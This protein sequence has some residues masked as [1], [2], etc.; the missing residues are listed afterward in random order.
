MTIL[1]SHPRMVGLGL[2]QQL[3]PLQSRKEKGT[4]GTGV[5]VREGERFWGQWAI[6]EML[7]REAGALGVGM[8]S[9]HLSQK[10]THSSLIHSISPLSS[11][12]PLCFLLNICLAP[13]PAHSSRGTS[14]TAHSSLPGPTLPLSPRA[15][16]APG[17]RVWGKGRTVSLATQ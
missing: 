2:S 6:Q 8:R 3:H 13:S 14:A 11:P 12:G 16:P 5:G 10:A 9:T 1:R 15:F 7:G 4:A 17:E